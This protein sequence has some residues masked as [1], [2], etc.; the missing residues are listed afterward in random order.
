MQCNAIRGG[1]DE[2]VLQQDR[3]SYNVAEEGAYSYT[4]AQVQFLANVGEGCKD[5]N[6]KEGGATGFL[7]QIQG[8]GEP[9]VG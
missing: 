6:C 9:N 8:E 4:G 3:I 7:L 1:S 5:E 2:R